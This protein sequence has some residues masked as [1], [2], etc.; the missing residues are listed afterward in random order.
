MFL[1]AGFIEFFDNVLPSNNYINWRIQLTSL[2][3]TLHAIKKK[4]KKFSGGN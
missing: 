1:I 2:C 4:K 3:I